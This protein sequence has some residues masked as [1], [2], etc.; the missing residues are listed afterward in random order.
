[1]KLV[2]A[3]VGTRMP[4]WVDE[5]F[6]D[7]VKRMPRELPLELLAVKA[8][9]RSEGKTVEVMM[10]A[11][12]Q[13]LRAAIPNRCRTIALDE[14]GTELTTQNLAQRLQR[15]MQEG[16]DTAFLIGGPDGLDPALKREATEQ[17]RLSGLTLPHAMVRVMLAEA[18]YRAASVI[19]GHP[20][21]R[22]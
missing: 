4:G 10:G 8:E 16:D 20:Y 3:A 5:G 6:A 17:V 11:E 15:W 9:P 22:E 18:L 21:H 14:R 2:I 1:M 7:Y 13:R 12:A 19:R